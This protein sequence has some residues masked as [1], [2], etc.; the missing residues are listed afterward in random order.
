VL[1]RRRRKYFPKFEEDKE[2]QQLALESCS[3]SCGEIEKER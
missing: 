1:R 2:L 3:V